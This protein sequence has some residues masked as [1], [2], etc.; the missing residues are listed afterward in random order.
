MTRVT[1]RL[2]KGV[3][4]ELR[5]VKRKNPHLSLNAVIVEAVNK[6]L[7]EKKQKQEAARA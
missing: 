2:P 5:R 6:G 1:V 7:I 4:E 3:Y